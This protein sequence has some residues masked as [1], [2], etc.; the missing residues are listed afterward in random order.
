V[1]VMAIVSRRSLLND[2]LCARSAGKALLSGILRTVHQEHIDKD[3][4]LL[5]V[6]GD[7]Y[8]EKLY[9]SHGMTEYGREESGMP[10]LKV[11]YPPKCVPFITETILCKEMDWK[12]ISSIAWRLVPGSWFVKEN[13]AH[14]IP[15]IEYWKQMLRVRS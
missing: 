14:F 5:G 3:L 12:D 8:V 1:N 6:P 15:M 7:A 2:K 9:K 11:S 13:C 10:K 4:T